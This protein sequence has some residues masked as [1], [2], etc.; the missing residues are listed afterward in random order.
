LAP[1][2]TDHADEIPVTPVRDR[3]DGVGCAA[4]AL[5]A[6]C[7]R[8]RDR[9]RSHATAATIQINVGD[10]RHTSG[11]NNSNYIKTINQGDT[12]RGSSRRR[13]CTPSRSAWTTR[14]DWGRIRLRSQELVDPPWAHTFDGGTFYNLHPHWA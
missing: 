6:S 13:A 11:Y 1:V 2:S 7:H 14:V 10:A 9:A 8:R 4:A 12:I 3:P 5:L